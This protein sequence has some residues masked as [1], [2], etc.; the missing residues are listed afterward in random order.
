[1]LGC[2]SKSSA[3]D[4]YIPGS[5]D[6]DATQ[7]SNES[8]SFTRPLQQAALG[9]IHKN[10][11]DWG[12]EPLYERQF[13]S[14][15]HTTTPTDIEVSIMQF[16]L[17]ADGL[18]GLHPEKGGFLGT[19][20]EALDWDSRRWRLLEE[21]VRFDADIVCLEECDHFD[22]WFEPQLA[23]LDYEGVF[24]KKPKSKCLD[25]CTLEDGC[26]IFWR[27]DKFSL[28]AKQMIFYS[29][30]DPAPNTHNQVAVVLT[31][32][33]IGGAATSAFMIACTH[34]KAEKTAE[35]EAVR[36]LEAGLLLDVMQEAQEGSPGQMPL[37][38]CADLNAAPHAGKYEALAYPAVLRHPLEM[39]S[40]YGS[41]GA[42]SEPPFTTYKERKDKVSCHT[43]DFIFHNDQVEPVSLLEIPDK[44]GMIAMPNYR[45]PSDHFSLVSNLRIRQG[46]TG[47]PSTSN[48][49][50]SGGRKLSVMSTN[51]LQ[52]LGSL[53]GTIG[54]FE[55]KLQEAQALVDA[56]A[57]ASAL[58]ALLALR[59]ELAQIN[60]SIEKLQ[61]TG[62]DAVV[63]AELTSG[64]A[65]AKGR[66]KELTMTAEKLHATAVGL[67]GQLERAITRCGG[68][69]SPSAL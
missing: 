58:P 44:A 34:L 39:K 66:R 61:C 8:P 35:G 47:A 1:M 14:C 68:E 57:D 69:D 37:I 45:Y 33:P 52:T 53:E 38:V 24:Q 63:T 51:T 36:E 43:I 25:F 62:I 7:P 9:K 12:W 56:A 41:K 4:V 23:A 28:V 6:K 40:V 67:K 27:K 50:A 5:S 15:S 32:K 29:K 17:L 18:S 55:K 2:C 65:E 64:K 54:G 13:R 26:A 20:P 46:D 42:D 19:P 60:G 21:I 10:T 30:V 31:L 48:G 59:G 22:D 49:A 3:S 11:E 16:N